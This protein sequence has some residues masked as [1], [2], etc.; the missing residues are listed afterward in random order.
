MYRKTEQSTS[1]PIDIP[2]KRVSQSRAKGNPNPRLETQQRRKNPAPQPELPIK[3]SPG[4]NLLRQG[5]KDG[6]AN[7]MNRE[8]P[9][10]ENQKGLG[11]LFSTHDYIHWS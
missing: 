2:K 11:T 3:T 10:T 8:G 5:R 6:G 1:A 4:Q 7:P 9:S